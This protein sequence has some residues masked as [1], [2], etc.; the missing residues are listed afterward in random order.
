MGKVQT[1]W[2]LPG[3]SGRACR[4]D[5]IYTKQNK[6][7]HQVYSVK[8]CHP[9]ENWTD[10]QVGHRSE[11][12]TISSGISAWIKTNK[13]LNSEDYQKVKRIF[14]RQCKY[15]TLRGMIYAKGYAK[16]NDEGQVVVTIGGSQSVVQTGGNTGG[17]TPNPNPSGGGDDN[18][19]F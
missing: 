13:E 12:G 7:T 16:L 1:N 2:L 10:K 11:F 17:T 19:T 18:G 14:D 3:H 15:G 8:L 6:K 5:N 9:N 4:H